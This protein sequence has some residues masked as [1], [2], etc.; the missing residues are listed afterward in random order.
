MPTEPVVKTGHFGATHY[1][2]KLKA[3]GLATVRAW[4]D[5]RAGVAPMT[6]QRVWEIAADFGA[7]K[8]IFPLLL[9][10]YITYTDASTTGIGTARH[11]TFPPANPKS[12]V[13][14]KNPLFF[15][16]EQLV[17][18]DEKARRLAYT[19]PVGMPVSNY[20]SVMQVTGD[21]ACRLTWTSTFKVVTGQ[22]GFVEVLAGILAGGA[23]QVATVLG[24]K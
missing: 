1:E 4:R 5:Y 15:G 3:N 19:S 14:P 6:A 16:I 13:S 12:P 7:V 9:S 22:E 23:N 11:M 2:S 24:L 20:K 8:T 17:E 10:V 21:D 18:F